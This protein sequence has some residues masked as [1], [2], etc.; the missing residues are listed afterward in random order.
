MSA[1]S[2]SDT[3]AIITVRQPLL[4]ALHSHPR[5]NANTNSLTSQ[6]EPSGHL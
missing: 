4:P 2:E 6:P 5:L 1:E 3:M